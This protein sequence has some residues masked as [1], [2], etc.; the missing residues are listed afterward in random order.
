MENKECQE[1]GPSENV[2]QGVEGVADGGEN[3]SDDEDACQTWPRDCHSVKERCLFAEHL[4][5]QV[6]E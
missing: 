2:K 3:E 4:F 6:G 1:A 5:Q